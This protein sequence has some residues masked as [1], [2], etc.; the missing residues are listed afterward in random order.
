MALTERQNA[1]FEAFKAGKSIVITG[2]GGCGKSFLIH[3]MKKYAEENNIVLAATAT[4][5]AAAA[6]I[7]GVTIHSWSGIGLGTESA[8]VLFKKLRMRK[9]MTER[10]RKTQCLIIDEISMLDASLFNLLHLL[11]QKMRYNQTELFGGIQLVV[12]GDFAQLPP[13]S[14]TPRFAFLSTVWRDHLHANTFYLDRIL[15]QNDPDF[16]EMLMRI[17]L[18]ETNAADKRILLSRKKFSYDDTVVNIEMENGELKPIHPTRLYPRKR[19]VEDNNEAELEK[20]IDS[21][22]ECKEYTCFDEAF[23]TKSKVPRKITEQQLAILDK[24]KQIAKKILL[25][26]GAQVMLTRNIDTE[27][28]L[29]NGSTGFINSFIDGDPEVIF[30]NGETLICSAVKCEVEL[31]TVTLCRT[32]VPLILAWAITIHK[33]QGATLTNVVTDLS[34]AFED[35]QVYV[36][37]SRVRSLDGLFIENINFRKIKCHPTV[38]Q[39]YTE[40]IT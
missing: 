23:E 11:G 9:H 26:V 2:P 4:T 21:G 27:K 18:G 31:G 30:D 37:L 34:E 29:V 28:G 20:L 14:D 35:G 36:T 38:K 40:L 22:A 6:Q 15:R 7:K 39:Y 16:Q 13:I 33:C 19:D 8:E 1:A 25:C 10:W 17:R 24:N 5:G 12:T 3:H 32:Q